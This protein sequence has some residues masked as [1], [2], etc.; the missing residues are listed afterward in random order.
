MTEQ[1]R[2][3]YDEGCL[4]AHA[5]NLVGDRWALLVLRELMLA[6]KRFQQ[7]RAGLP[8]ITAAVLT[9]RLTQLIGSG[10]VRHDAR[11]GIYGA[12]ASGRG[13]LPVL[14]A[15][16][17]WG[18][19]HPGHDPRRFISPTA[20][21]ISMTAMIDARAAQ[22]LSLRAGFLIGREGFVQRLTEDGVLHPE[23]QDRPDA[24]FTLEGSG[25]A[26]ARAVYGGQPLGGQDDVVVHGD[27]ALAQRFLGLFRLR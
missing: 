10:V 20:L 6:D 1:S 13:L 22:G 26:L 15:L 3:R 8:G 12:T 21:M 24:D 5:L 19:A 16:C 7:I 9:Q 27:G 14:Q 4:A 18:A 25:N 11:L 23:A 2:L 17:R